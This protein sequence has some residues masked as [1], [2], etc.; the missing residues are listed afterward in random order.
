M[1]DTFY[2]YSKS[3]MNDTDI[4]YSGR[5]FGGMAI[6]CKKSSLFKYHV[7]SIPSDRIMCVSVNDNAGKSVQ[8]IFNV[9]MP[10]YNSQISQTELYT[11]T[12][13][14][15]QCS[16]D[17]YGNVAPVQILGDFNVKLPQYDVSKSKTWFR[18]N[19]FNRHS[20]IMHDFL[21]SNNLYIADQCFKQRNE[22][23]YF[24]H[25]RNVFTWIDHIAISSQSLSNVQSCEI[26]DMDCLN[27]SDHL[28]VRLVLKI[29][30]SDSYLH[31]HKVH[32]Y[33]RAPPIKWEKICKQKYI[34]CVQE[35]LD[36]LPHVSPHE[37]DPKVIDEYMESFAKVLID[38]AYCASNIP[39]FHFRPKPYWCPELSKLRDKKRFWWRI[40]NDC[41]RPRKGAVYECYKGA[42][43]LFRKFCRRSAK[44]LL[45][46]SLTEINSLFKDGHMTKFWQKI[47]LR[48]KKKVTSTLDAQSF[49]DHFSEIM[50]DRESENLTREQKQIKEFV[51]NKY[52][53]LSGTSCHVPFTDAE[54]NDAITNLKRNV[55]PGIDLL[56]A[57]HF[58]HAN[59]PELRS[60]LVDLYNHLLSCSAIP[61]DISLGMIIP[62][63][64]KPALNPNI[65][66]NFRPITLGSIHCKLLEFLLMPSDC[67][68][69]NQFGF[70]KGR[71]TSMAA[72]LL[73][74]VIVSAKYSSAPMF[75]C[76]LDAEKCFD[77]L[78]HYGLFFKLF[79]KMPDSHWLFLLSWYKNMKSIVKWENTLSS[80]FSVTRGTK[81]GSILSPAL[82]NIFINDLL[83]ELSET[84]HG[85]RFGESVI[86]SFAYADDVTLISPIISGLQNLI[87][88]CNAYADKWRFKFGINK[89]H[90]MILN[91]KVFTRTPTWLLGRQEIDIVDELEILGCC[92]DNK[93]SGNKHVE[94]R[95]QACRKSMYSLSEI[96]CC[97]PGLNSNVK[98]HLWKSIGQPTLLYGLDSMCINGANIKRLDTTQA[99]FIKRILG[100]KQRTHHSNLLRAVN[101]HNIEHYIKRNTISLWRRSFFIDSLLRSLCAFNLARYIMH[102]K[103]IPG[104]IVDR[105]V[106]YG[107]SPTQLLLNNTQ[108]TVTS[109][110]SDGVA[111]SLRYL[112]M[113]ENFLKPYS[114]EHVIA[115]L[116]VKAF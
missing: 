86:N 70:R 96:G 59:S 114:D 62:I 26:C 13:D 23:T 115:S 32:E 53:Q 54:L 10:F 98:T 41:H 15:L 84:R 97:Y 49:A 63:L 6:I 43:K 113:N 29:R 64:K 20:L 110:T 25:K 47:K 116:L 39:K 75:I 111:D 81:Q 74:D 76:S 11:E 107:M 99:S 17:Q 36:S 65:P 27:T 61:Y 9:Y 34:T 85:A 58:I 33:A 35:K 45:N 52:S 103:L 16:I 46:S 56:T 88:V 42:K 24:S 69:M 44:D 92:F 66:N 77:S 91:G 79:S 72:A 48:N 83:V 73:N 18:T 93:V 55:S 7:I 95:I 101:I 71:G 38:S 4:S 3:S 104:T 57:E 102:G 1:T 82:F 68:H 67:A 51:L 21:L 112:I 14:I 40:W 87:N 109:V 90:C 5:P 78:W 108:Y 2:V 50:S 105:I 28:P 80:E 106:S 30:G 22:F 8:L 60:H 89:T 94:K 100:F 12:I 31:K 37:H 19:G